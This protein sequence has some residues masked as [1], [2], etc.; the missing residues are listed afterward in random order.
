M[1]YQG[2]SAAL[3]MAGLA[4]VTGVAVVTAPAADARPFCDEAGGTTRCQTNGSTS[5]KARPGT[6]APPAGS[7]NQ[8][9][10]HP[11]GR[12][13]GGRRGAGPFPN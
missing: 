1:R 2:K 7:R 4:A 13:I 10:W 6:L 8:V 3:L 9:P 12:R 5:I 11:G